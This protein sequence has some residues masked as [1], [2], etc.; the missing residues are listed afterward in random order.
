[1]KEDETEEHEIKHSR[2]KDQFKKGLFFYFRE[3]I[4]FLDI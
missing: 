4:F 2:L 1:M 3:K